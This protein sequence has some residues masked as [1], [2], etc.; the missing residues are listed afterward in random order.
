MGVLLTAVGC[1]R[2][3]DGNGRAATV[4]CAERAGPLE[5]GTR[6]AE[7]AGTYELT[8]VATSGDSTGSRAEGRLTLQ[9]NDSAHAVVRG[10]GSDTPRP[11]VSTPLF[12]WTDLPAGQVDAVNTGSL[13]ATDPDA[14][15]VLVIESIAEETGTPRDIILRLGAFSN[16]RGRLLF[17]GGY[18]VLRVSWIDDGAFGGSWES[19]AM[20]YGSAG[21][22]FCARPAAP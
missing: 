10:M 7:L 14:P 18:T 3:P 2:P 4:A 8:L 9:P 13:G 12:G 21:G 17:D 11:N 5:G 19:A 16:D 1:A 22:Y 20:N 6:A 15:G